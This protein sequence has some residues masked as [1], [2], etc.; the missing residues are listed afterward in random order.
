MPNLQA[1][2]WLEIDLS[3]VRRNVAAVRSL[4]G[5]SCEILAVVKA[6]AYGHGAVRVSQAALAGGAWGL[7]V[8]NLAEA[9]EL[10]RAGLQAPILL[11]TEGPMAEAPEVVRLSLL[12]T[13]YTLETAQALS[14]AALRFGMT[15]QAHIKVDT[16]MGRLGIRPQEAQAFAAAVAALPALRVTGLFSH[17]ATAEE[18]EESFALGQFARFRACLEQISGLKAHIANSAGLLKFPQM[19]LDFVRSGLLVYG[20]APTSQLAGELPLQPALTWKTRVAFA[21]TIPAGT[22]VSYGRTW[23]ASSPTTV[24]TLPVGYADGYPR[25]LSNRGQALFRGRPRPVVG[26]VCMNHI[27]LDVGDEPAVRPDEEV[28]LLG[29][30]GNSRITATDLAAWA[31]TCPHEILARLS[32]HLPR[33]YTG[34]EDARSQ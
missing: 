1:P 5:A 21:K 9:A 32:R 26:T 15:A 4:V 20:V 18:E 33:P 7:C 27:L 12:Q 6:D 25:T 17:L 30:Q 14:Q 28:I 23:K 29:Q 3:A 11:L 34:G 24:A 8:A 2:S 13:L 16:G 19:R 22:P 10:R 31:D